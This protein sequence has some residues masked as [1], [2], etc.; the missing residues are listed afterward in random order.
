MVCKNLFNAT[1]ANLGYRLPQKSRIL[2]V[3][4][5]YCFIRFS[6]KFFLDY[7]LNSYGALN[8]MCFF[9]STVILMGSLDL[10]SI[11]ILVI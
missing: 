4:L 9:N 11:S 6:N 1:Y 5:G 3:E 8:D 7:G 10:Q 2:L